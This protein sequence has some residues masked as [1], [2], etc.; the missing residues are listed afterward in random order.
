[1]KLE[2]NIKLFW[3]HMG[4][5]IQNPRLQFGRGTWYRTVSELVHIWDGSLLCSTLH[6]KNRLFGSIVY[7]VYY[8]QEQCMASA[9]CSWWN[10]RPSGDKDDNTC[11]SDKQRQQHMQ[12]RQTKTT[13][14]AGQTN[15]VN[16]TCR[17][18][19]QR[20][21]HLK[22]SLTK[23]T[24]VAGQSDKAD[25][26]C[27]SVWQRKQD[28]QVSMTKTTTLAGQSVKDDSTSRSVW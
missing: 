15:K 17:S 12:V 8:P 16:S 19:R 3:N 26:T 24:T 11:R 2:V 27:R 18:V 20:R 13:T 4:T 22:V 28:L 5:Q 23:T 9:S 7:W 1:M 25:N 6:E 21:Q 14:H 10:F